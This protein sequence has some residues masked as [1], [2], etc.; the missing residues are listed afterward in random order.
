MHSKGW[1]IK[2]AFHLWNLL[3]LETPETRW[4]SD[5]KRLTAE[6]LMTPVYAGAGENKQRKQRE[7][8]RVEFSANRQ[9]GRR[10]VGL[11]TIHQRLN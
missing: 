2:G 6:A 3:G 4:S 8:Q 10:N 1:L 5:A 7:K 11:D 9:S